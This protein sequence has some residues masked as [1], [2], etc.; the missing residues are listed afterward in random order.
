MIRYLNMEK[1]SKNSS[2]PKI[3]KKVLPA[4]V[5]IIVSKMLPVF[6]APFGGPQNPFDPNTPLMAPKGNKKIDVGGGSGFI[7]DPSGIILTNRHV[8][9]DPEAEYI[10]IVGD[11]E[12][13][14][15]QVLARDSIHDVAILKIDRTNLPIIELGNSSKLELGQTSIAIGNALGT[16]RNTVSVGVISGLAREISAGDTTNNTVT[17]LRGLVQTDAA[18][19][20]GNS[21]G[22][23][24]DIKGKVIGIN[25][26][27]IFFAE[28]I[29]FALP[30]NNA[31]KDL[32]D[33]KQHGRLRLP[34][35][36]I[37]YVLIDK[38]LQ[39]K[40]KLSIDH[41]AFVIAEKTPQS[42][43]ADAVVVGST[44]HQAG[45]KEGDI[46]LE[47]QNIKVSAKC[48]LEDIL[49]KCKIGENLNLKIFRD[50]QEIALKVRLDERK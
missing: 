20:P 6:E 18:I 30:I 45:V 25:T 12:K 7:V 33:L 29:G 38:E 27:M 47:V 35:L 48:P 11:D 3:V 13:C 39:E 34:F 36:G 37:R 49:Q 1:Y 23:L 42:P 41:G 46:I 10:V 5:S 9:N 40:F 26:A 2:I 43:K 4:V 8:V 22:P 14:P 32:D 15:A 31:K 24:I 16:F 17:K 50:N 28:N 19:N 21:G 44:A